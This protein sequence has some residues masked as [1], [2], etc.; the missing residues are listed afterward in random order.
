MA[1]LTESILAFCRLLRTEYDIDVGQDRAHEALLALETVRVSDR[2]RVRYAL[3]L[4]LCSSPEQL[5]RFDAAFERFFGA[6]IRR[7]PRMRGAIHEEALAN[8]SIRNAHPQTGESESNTSTI[9]AARYSAIAS[10]AASDA[11][12]SHQGLGDTL[13]TAGKVLAALRLGRS[14]RW[15]PHIDGPRFDFRGTLRSSLHTGGDPA[16][17]RTLGHPLRNPRIVFILDASRSMS[18]NAAALLQ[19]AYALTRR[20]A[21]VRVF[22]FSTALREVTRELRHLRHNERLPDFGEAWGGGTRISAALEE[23]EARF[24]SRLDADTLVIIASDGF[25]EDAGAKLQRPLRNIDRRSAGIIWLNP[26]AGSPGFQPSARAMKTALP[27]I[28]T[29]LDANKTHSIP[30]AALRLRR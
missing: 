15:K 16:H 28:R 7:T 4:S 12:V 23:F 1:D 20:S 18:S 14:R 19:F 29:L 13:R 26:H 25:D 17:I 9:L 10:R 5:A 30:A 24:G 8:G 3:R 11:A 6:D 22:A 21:R 27:Y 2:E